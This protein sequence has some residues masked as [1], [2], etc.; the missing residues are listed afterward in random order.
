MPES[1]LVLVSSPRDI[2]KMLAMVPFQIGTST[3]FVVPFSAAT[4][5]WGRGNYFDKKIIY[6]P[7][8]LVLEV[9]ESMA[10][11]NTSVERHMRD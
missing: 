3:S 8:F 9:M 11:M 6:D 7:T 10:H 1:I 5:I 2:N 4:L